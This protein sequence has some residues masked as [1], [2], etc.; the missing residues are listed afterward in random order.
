[1]TTLKF[2]CPKGRK[3]G[4]E[5]SKGVRQKKRQQIHGF[6]RVPKHDEL[7]ALS[8]TADM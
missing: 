2:E 3:G 6:F 5:A 8:V 7:L 1:M 4:I